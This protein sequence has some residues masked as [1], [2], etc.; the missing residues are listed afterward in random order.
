MNTI[1]KFTK[2]VYTRLEHDYKLSMTLAWILITIINI[3]LIILVISV[4]HHNKSLAS[5]NL[6]SNTS[7]PTI[8]K[9]LTSK[10]RR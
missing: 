1:D 4:Q 3:S 9:K 10:L 7:K 5:N 8:K 6:P 2:A